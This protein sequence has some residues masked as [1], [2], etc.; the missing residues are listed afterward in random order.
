MNL[1]SVKQLMK[2]LPISQASIYRMIK[3]KKIP[4]YRFENS[5]R[6]EKDEIHSWIKG[7]S[8]KD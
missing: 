2:I 1:I 4:H 6:F 7:K 8:I 5:V 3:N